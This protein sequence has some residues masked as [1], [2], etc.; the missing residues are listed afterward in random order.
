MDIKKKILEMTGL[1]ERLTSLSS[2]FSVEIILINMRRRWQDGGPHL[3]LSSPLLTE[4]WVV[5]QGTWIMK[6][7]LHP[8][9]DDSTNSALSVI[10]WSISNGLCQALRRPQ[11]VGDTSWHHLPCGL[12]TRCLSACGPVAQWSSCRPSDGIERVVR[13]WSHLAPNSLGRL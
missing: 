11:T 4:P 12:T 8:S 5:W 2:I 7:F 1:R 13:V 9:P 10:Y 6:Q 3:Q